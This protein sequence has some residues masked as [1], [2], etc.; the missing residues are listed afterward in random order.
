MKKNYPLAKLFAVS[1][2]FLGSVAFSMV[3]RANIY[4]FS[5]TYSGANENPPNASTATG[6]IIGTYDDFTNRI[7]FTVSFSG[8]TT[9]ATGAHFHAPAPPGSNSPII[10]PFNNFPAAT[11]GSYSGSALVTD[12]QETQ[13]FAG[14]WYAN[15]HSSTF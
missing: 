6:T 13:L 5:L 8:L 10:I 15:I 12:L 11:S 4:P 7:F 3:A 1:F 2:F 14:L 9:P